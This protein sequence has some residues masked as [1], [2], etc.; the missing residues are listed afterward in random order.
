MHPG[1]NILFVYNKTLLQ[2]FGLE[3]PPRDWT[4][5]DLAEMAIA[6]T[7]K[8]RGIFGVS[9][10][11]TDFHKYGQYTRAWGEPT[12]DDKSGWLLSED[13]KT[14]RFLENEEAAKLSSAAQGRRCAWPRRSGRGHHGPLWRWCQV[15]IGGQVQGMVTAQHRRTRSSSAT[16]SARWAPRAGLTPATKATSG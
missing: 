10:V 15:F 13:G 11:V 16:R 9:W 8:E 3:E 7:D 14:F 1:S 2:E 12:P 6:C 4:Y 5:Q